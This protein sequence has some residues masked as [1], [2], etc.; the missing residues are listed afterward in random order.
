MPASVSGFAGLHDARGSVLNLFVI[1][2]SSIVRFV[3]SSMTSIATLTTLSAS[4][5]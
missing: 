4:S 5:W 3:P 1:P 2:S